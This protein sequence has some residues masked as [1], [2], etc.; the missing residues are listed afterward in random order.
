M[1]E[2]DGE[3][4]C[5]ADVAEGSYF[6]AGVMAILGLMAAVLVLSGLFHSVLRRVGQ[7]SIISHIL[8]RILVGCWR[9]NSISS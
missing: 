1:A 5:S 7:P 9:I 2:V 4:K 8:V 6:M 3:A